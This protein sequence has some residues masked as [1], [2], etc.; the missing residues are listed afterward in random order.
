MPRKTLSPEFWDEIA[1]HWQL[2]QMTVTAIARRYDVNTSSIYARARRDGWPPRHMRRDDPALAREALIA[3][4]VFELRTSLA[5][6]RNA[7]PEDIASARDRTRLIREYQRSLAALVLKPAA[8][9]ANPAAADNTL[10]LD[11]EAAKRDVLD[12][13]ARLDR[14]DP[15]SPRP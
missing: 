14:T 8:A 11:L 10:T 9:P 5:R 2:G 6:L 3:D 12:R 4:L 13:L 1:R 15:E 7:P